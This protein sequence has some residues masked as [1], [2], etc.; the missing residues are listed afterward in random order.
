MRYNKKIKGAI[1]VAFRRILAV[2]DIHGHADQ[3]RTL[4]KKIAFDDKEDM[5]VFLGDYIDRG[6]K[7]VE[8]LRFVQKQ[9]EC[10]ENVH[11][12]C[13][14]HEAMMLGYLRTHGLD[15]FDPMDLWLM[16]GGDVTLDQLMGLSAEDAEGLIA[17]VK[18]CPLYDRIQHGGQSILFVHAGINPRQTKQKARD[19][20][21][22]REDFYD[23]YRGT[24]LVVVGH[25]PTQS[26]GG[27]DMSRNVPLFLKNNIIACDTGSFLPGGRISCVDVARYLD[28]RAEGREMTAEAL[29]SCY[30]QSG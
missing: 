27:R 2:G 25:T 28:L 6:K 4:W 8:A 7:S 1:F 17:F 24:E 29:A 5:L 16:N 13:G 22:I 3:L 12:L 19:L 14:N 21:W 11:A 26:L 18:A 20:L 15:D 30:E 9:V 23:N 10:H